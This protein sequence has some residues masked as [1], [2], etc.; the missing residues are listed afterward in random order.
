MAVLGLASALAAIALPSSTQTSEIAAVLL[1]GSLA[2]LAGHGWGLAIVVLAE[3]VL[4]GRLMPLIVYHWPPTPAVR[5]AAT[6]ALAGA[7][8]SVLL[9]R[10][11][12]ADAVVLCVGTRS[13]LAHSLGI[14]SGAALAAWLMIMPLM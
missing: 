1:V 12:L 4:L 10:H 9:I 14:A 5:W 8:P 3:L 6:L 11:A 7:A 13:G 2:S